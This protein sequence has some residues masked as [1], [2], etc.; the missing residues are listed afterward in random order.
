MGASPSRK[1]PGVAAQKRLRAAIWPSRRCPPFTRP[2]SGTCTRRVK[3]AACPAPMAAR[4]ALLGVTARNVPPL[5]TYA[6][7]RARPR[8][9]RRVLGQLRTS[10]WRAALS[11]RCTTV[12]GMPAARSRATAAAGERSPCTQI[13]APLGPASGRLGASGAS[14][15]A[16]VNGPGATSECEPPM[17]WPASWLRRG[18]AVMITADTAMNTATSRR[19][20][21]ARGTQ[22]ASAAR[23][24]LAIEHTFA[25]HLSPRCWSA[26]IS[27]GSIWRSPRTSTEWRWEARRWRS[28]RST[29]APAPSAR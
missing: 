26:S 27:P 28:R 1:P 23:R 25:Y 15:R 11:K 4:T 20:G 29:A 24:P 9:P 5:R 8:A 7:T 21:R 12:A 22:P 2:R 17:P 19:S 10:G 18:P 3:K 14:A 13:A 6:R 16:W